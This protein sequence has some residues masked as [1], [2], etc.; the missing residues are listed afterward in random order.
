MVKSLP[1]SAGDTGLITDQGI[2]IPHVAGQLSLC[3]ATAE[4]ACISKDPA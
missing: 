2:K 4:P 3:S 1:C